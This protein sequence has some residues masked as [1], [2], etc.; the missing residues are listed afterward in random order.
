MI[1]PKSRTYSISSSG[2][3]SVIGA[4][5]C[6]HI[7]I[8]APPG[9][10]EGDFVNRKGFHSVNVQVLTMGSCLV[11]GAMPARQYFMMPFPDPN[12]RPQTRFNAALA[13]TRARIEMT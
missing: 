7:P 12:P 8:K 9:P 6:T 3:P 10:N 2:F 4:I 5:D 11:T 13:R 1:M